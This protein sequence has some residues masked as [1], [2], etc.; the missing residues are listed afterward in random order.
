MSAEG[1]LTLGI[2]LFV[3]VIFGNCRDFHI[4]LRYDKRRVS[5]KKL[6]PMLSHRLFV[7]LQINMKGGLCL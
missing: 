2:Y 6:K 5:A 3:K 1:L 7:D 4:N